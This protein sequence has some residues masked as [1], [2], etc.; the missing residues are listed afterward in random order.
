M[1]FTLQQMVKAAMRGSQA[2]GLQKIAEEENDSGSCEA[3]GKTTPPGSKMCRECAAKAAKAEAVRGGD[4]E[5]EGEEKTSSLRVEKLASAVEEVLTNW[6]DMDW[7]LWPHFKAAAGVPTASPGTGPGAGSTAMPNT[8]K[9]PTPGTQ[10]TEFGEAKKNK[11]PMNPPM[12]VPVG[13]GKGAGNAME[14]NIED[15][16]AAYPADGV[17]KQG[18]ITAMY[19]NVMRKM[20]ADSDSASVSGS[21]NTMLPENQP[22][23]MKRPPEVTSQEAMVASN[24]AAIDA[25]KRQAKEVPKRRMGEVIEERA[26][27]AATDKALDANLDSATVDRA[28]AKIAAARVLLQKVASQGCSCGSES[29]NEGSCSFCKL[30]S[31]IEDR[32]RGERMGKASMMGAAPMPAPA[33]APTAAPSAGAAPPPPVPGSPMPGTGM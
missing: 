33:T 13:G 26:Q 5:A 31:R 27:S 21:K 29:P 14:D 7:S 2:E 28:G 9:T 32:K 30:A 25:T 20:G 11:P 15:L 19:Q 8:D 1:R 24:Q 6:D 4:S 22:S 3:C 12:G 16:R 18:S 10:A 23:Q 17:M